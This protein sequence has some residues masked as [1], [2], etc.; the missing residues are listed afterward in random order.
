MLK[1]K[2]VILAAGKGTRMKAEV[3]KPLVQIAGKPMIAHLLERIAATGLD[4]KPVVVVSAEN[5]EIF[6]AQ[7]GD[8]VEYA[9]Q[10]EQ[11]GTAHA[12]R[13]AEKACGEAQC[14]VVLYGDHPFLES[15]V[16]SSLEQLSGEHFGSLIMLTA[17]V[18]NFDQPYD[19]FKA[20]GRILRDAQDKVV[21]IVE[22]KEATDK[23]LESTE[24]N[25]AMFA[26]P[27]PW[28]WSALAEIKNGNA[29][30]EYYLTDI[31]EIAMNQGKEI[32]TA[33]VDALQ[34]M[35]V[36][37]PEELRLAEKIHLEQE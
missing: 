21:G 10:T 9:V 28:I 14:V 26:F 22:A 12:L 36:N 4:N 2:V 32:V 11:L 15:S 5:V 16:I 33:S 30:G 27:S 18:P 23:Q 8:S 20:W 35:G 13:A 1:T 7:L 29:K 37:T 31:I 34:V 19:V 24:I 6:K 17:K 3:P 25:P